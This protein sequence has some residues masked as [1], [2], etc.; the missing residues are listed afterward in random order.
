MN[1]RVLPIPLL[2]DVAARSCEGFYQE[3]DAH[4]LPSL[5]SACEVARDVRVCEVPLGIQIKLGRIPNEENHGLG[6]DA[7]LKSF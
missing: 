6:A 5:D 1:E 7:S 2:E 4:G 3:A